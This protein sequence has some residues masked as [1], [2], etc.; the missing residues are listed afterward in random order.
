MDDPLLEWR[1]EFP[2]LEKT[3]Y[4]IS[5]SLGAM[6]R[7]VYDSM[8]E[9][10]ET[11][12]TRGVRA[13][14]EGWW[15]MAVAAGDLIASIIGAEPGQISMH[16]NVTIV[17][18]IIVS[19][20]DFGWRRNKIVYTD[21]NFPSVAYIYQAQRENGARI[22]E[23][24]TEDHVSVPTEK[25]IEAIDDETLLVPVSHVLFR[26]AYIQDAKAIIEQ[27]HKKGAYV[28][29]DTYQSCGTVPFNVKEL[30]ADFVTGGSVK[31][32][33]GGPGA[34][35]LYV[36][37]DLTEDLKPKLTGWMAH[38]RP[39]DFEIEG[40]D[41]RN[42]AYRFLNGTP[43]VP[44]LY[45]A[46]CGYRIVNE[47]GVDRIREKSMH[48]TARLIELALE[49]GM[50][51]TAPMRPEQRGGTIAINVDHAYEVSRELLAREFIVD[52]R[53]KAGVRI[54][55]HFYN[56]D[57]ELEAIIKEIRAIID[58]GAYKRHIGARSVTK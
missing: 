4:M 26:S 15:E 6:P 52:Y 13:W 54:S 28:V 48:Q 38:R 22:V 12:A 39:F 46:R 44:A 58:T 57:E 49:H 23:V 37:P 53:P 21:M 47:I 35:Y 50:K 2:I 18:A 8:H 41:Y 11:W 3:V 1:K 7:A 55:P 17:E 29:L 56:S 30:D 27:A 34:A 24:K 10:A 33:C 31:W 14:N 19:C 25:V 16:Q 20:F 51:V 45:A 40:M 5:N 9:F 43:P 36:R 32:L 42:D